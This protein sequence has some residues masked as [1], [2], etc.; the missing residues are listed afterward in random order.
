MT[1][2]AIAW[3]P[4]VEMGPAAPVQLLSI[5]LQNLVSC[6]QHASMTRM[7]LP[8]GTIGIF[9]PISRPPALGLRMLKVLPPALA[10]QRMV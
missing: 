8:N 7:T 2:E 6:T 5:V 4:R 9:R 3:G 10:L 1:F